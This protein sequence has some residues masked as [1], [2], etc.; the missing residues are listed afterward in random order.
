MLKAFIGLGF[1]RGATI[2]ENKESRRIAKE[3]E[4]VFDHADKIDSARLLETT[5][6]FFDGCTVEEKGDLITVTQPE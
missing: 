4:Q 1:Y 5:K 2:K 3:Q 6:T